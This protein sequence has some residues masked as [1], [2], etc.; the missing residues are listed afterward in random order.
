LVRLIGLSQA[1][2]MILTGYRMSAQEAQNAGY[3][4]RLFRPEDLDNAVAEISHTLASRP[5]LF[6]MEECFRMREAAELLLPGSR[7]DLTTMLAAYRDPESV[8]H[9]AAYTNRFKK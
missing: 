2:D 9:G 5:S 8:E 6:L 3:F 7:N 1:A 4:S